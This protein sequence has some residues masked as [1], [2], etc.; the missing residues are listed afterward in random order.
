MQDLEIRGLSRATV[1]LIERRATL[2]NRAVGDEARIMLDRELLEEELEETSGRLFG[3]LARRLQL[4]K[5]RA[6]LIAETLARGY[7][8]GCCFCVRR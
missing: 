6:R 5:K 1:D 3:L 4:G 8:H 2:H 7:G